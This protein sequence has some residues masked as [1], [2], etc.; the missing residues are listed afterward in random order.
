MTAITVI[1]P[2]WNGM[3]HLP[4]AVRSVIDQNY[5][6]WELLIRDDGS[7]D[8]S[9]D[10]LATLSDPRIRLLATGDNL[11]IFGNLNALF[12]EARSPFSQIL[13]QDDRFS[14]PTALTEIVEAWRTM[15]DQIG[16]MACNTRPTPPS[17]GLL[18]YGQRA[19]PEVID[20]SSSDLCFFLFG[21]LCGNLSNVSLRT[22]LVERVGGF[23][24]RL[25]YA[26]DFDFWSRAG[27]LTAFRRS[28]A[29]WV[30]VRSHE[31]QASSHLN[32][33]GELVAQLYGLVDGL[34]R[35]LEQR[36]SARLLRLFAT[37]AYDAQHRWIGVKQRV[38]SGRSGYLAVV[39]AAGDQCAVFPRGRLIRWLV[40]VLALGG[41]A[42]VAP[43]AA[44]LLR[45]AGNGSVGPAEVTP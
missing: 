7:T 38:R 11:G 19:M 4:E 34:Y 33:K 42:G 13:C 21:C 20:P 37:A 23:D 35:R 24:Q 22:D 9:R 2:V 44:R 39:D 36:H 10:Y 1:M 26:G 43:L 18:G 30:S 3:P 8:G 28:A 41:R 40:F 32:R 25:P 14:G 12:A 5:T 6:D 17:K 15:P 16:F 29:T 31:G 45:G 27:R